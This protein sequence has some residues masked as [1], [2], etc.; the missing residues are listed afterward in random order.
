MRS[1]PASR[2]GPAWTASWLQTCTWGA[3]GGGR[4][5]PHW[6]AVAGYQ[7]RS[8]SPGST[9]RPGPAA[10][11]LLGGWR[12]L[13][14]RVPG[15]GWSKGAGGRCVPGRWVWRAAARW[16][17]W[18]SL[19]RA[20]G[21]CQADGPVGRHCWCSCDAGL[22]SSVSAAVICHYTGSFNSIT[23]YLPIAY[24]LMCDHKL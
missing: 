23:L 21:R 8:S 16:D 13:T 3:W 5:S 1:K 24:T 22:P 4:Q 19:R 14:D 10:S 15:C 18:S 12:V 2:Q 20:C 11:T 9:Q 6:R 7:R 17:L